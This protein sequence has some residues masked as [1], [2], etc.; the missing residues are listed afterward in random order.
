MKNLAKKLVKVFSAVESKV[1]KSGYN[2]H[3]NYAYVMESDLL[4]AVRGEL[5]KEGVLVTSSVDSVE[6]SDTITT[7]TTSHM[8]IDSETGESLTVKSAGQGSDKG[9]KGVYK[10]IT[11]SNKYFLL[12][13]F[14]LAGDDDPETDKTSNHQSAP[15]QTITQE[16]KVTSV[17]PTASSSFGKSEASKPSGF[18][19]PAST[20]KSGAAPKT[21][22]EA[23]AAINPA[24]VP[25]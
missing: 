24:D 23:A 22:A 9:D 6:R 2:N 8:F 14:M 3:Q 10:A 13:T 20:P 15:K 19:K 25:F 12:K 11:G 4:D 1:N 7:V 5:L 18:G 16:P 21:L 17:R